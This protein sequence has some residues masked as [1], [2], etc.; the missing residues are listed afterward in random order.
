[1]KHTVQQKEFSQKEQQ[2]ISS[3]L[4]Y[5]LEVFDKDNS[6]SNLHFKDELSDVEKQLVKDVIV[7]IAQIPYTEPKYRY[8]L[9]Q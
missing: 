7:H 6:I 2:M 5:V 1:M 9:E 8:E 4:S 3:L